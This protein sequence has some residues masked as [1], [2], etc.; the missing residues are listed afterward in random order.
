MFHPDSQLLQKFMKPIVKEYNKTSKKRILSP[1]SEIFLKKILGWMEDAEDSFSNTIIQE[2]ILDGKNGIPKGEMQFHIP[3]K[4]MDHMERMR[5]IGKKISFSIE[6]RTFHIFLLHPKTSQTESEIYKWIDGLK[7]RIYCWLYIASMESTKGCSKTMNIY[8]YLTDL[9]KK[10]PQKGENEI[11]SEINV[12]TAYTFACS[13]SET[14]ENEMYLYRKEEWFKVFIHETF[15]AFALDFANMRETDADHQILRMFPLNID[16][17]LFETYTE[18]WA[19]TMNIIYIVHSSNIKNKMEKIVEYL[20]MEQL[21]SLFQA[22]KVLKHN[23]ISYEELY[24]MT[25]RAKI[26]RVHHYKESSPV[27]AYYIL[28]SIC[29]MNVGEFIEWTSINNKGSLNFQKTKSNI[30]S[31]IHFIKERYKHEEFLEAMKFTENYYSLMKRKKM[32]GGFPTEDF[33]LGRNLRMSMFE[34]E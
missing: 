8:L 18:M 2:M 4:V 12:N 29:M 3:E 16:L 31:F 1:V 5:W 34:I 19:E 26:K 32:V 33:D 13:F 9:K 15:H 14:G 25:E 6:N 24:E 10:F 22:L 30:D 17:R 7:K 27:M 28:K 20:K 23:H 11:L 21:F